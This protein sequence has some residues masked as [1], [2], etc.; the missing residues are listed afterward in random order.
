MTSSKTIIQSW[1][2]KAKAYHARTRRWSIF[3]TLAERLIDFF[4]ENFDGCVLDLAGGGGLVSA[5]LTKKFPHA[6][7]YLL[8]PAKN[9]LTIAKARLGKRVKKYYP[10]RA[11]EAGEIPTHF[12]AAVCNVS[13]HLMDEKKVFHAVRRALKPGGMFC[14]NLWGHS[15]AP[16]AKLWIENPEKECVMKALRKHGEAMETYPKNPTPRRRT[17][18]ELKEAA[19]RAGL[20]LSRPIIHIDKLPVE[21]FIDFAAMSPAYPKPL[22]ALKQECILSDAKKFSSGHSVPVHT[23]RFKAS[24]SPP[25]L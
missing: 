16:T 23:A 8:E 25:S 13:F 21:F 11:D 20:K 14:F 1:H 19:S 3:T 24:M 18:K 15:Y 6:D 10:L 12:D 9:M 5:L 4:P 7:I 2:G 22:S 17:F